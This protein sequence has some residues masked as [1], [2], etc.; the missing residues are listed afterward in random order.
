M[1]E[2]KRMSSSNITTVSDLKK[3]LDGDFFNITP[4]FRGFLKKICEFRKV[5]SYKNIIHD[6]D[7]WNLGERCIKSLCCVNFKENRKSTRPKNDF[8]P[9]QNIKI[10][11]KNRSLSRNQSKGLDKKG[12]ELI[13]NNT[14]KPTKSLKMSQGRK[15]DKNQNID[16]RLRQELDFLKKAGL[17]KNHN[18]F[19]PTDHPRALL[20][21][22]YKHLGYK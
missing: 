14:M 6:Q 22:K 9:Y 1:L 18:I 15:I 4:E 10:A 20:E 17:T 2:V 21:K 16:Q 19:Y 11:K 7:L 5:S 13:R 12:S 3:Q 8:N